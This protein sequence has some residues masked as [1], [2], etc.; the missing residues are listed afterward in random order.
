MDKRHISL[1]HALM[2]ACFR[3]ALQAELANPFFFPVFNGQQVFSGSCPSSA[4]PEAGSG[5]FAPTGFDGGKL[6]R[7]MG[8]VEATC[9]S[10]PTV[11]LQWSFVKVS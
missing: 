3:P 10:R 7:S 11:F 9:F 8:N 5:P 1:E 2:N 4:S 6:A